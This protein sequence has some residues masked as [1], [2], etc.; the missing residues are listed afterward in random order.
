MSPLFKGQLSASTVT[1]IEI[2]VRCGCVGAQ[3][4]WPD[5][6]SAATIGL[7]FSSN[8]G[9]GASSTKAD[10]W[11]D[12]GVTI[13]GPAATGAGSVML[14]VDNIR[15]KRARIKVTTTAVTNLTVW[16]GMEPV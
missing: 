13:T 3:V 9:A 6:T 7:E 15:Q 5:A 12:S 8:P 1:Y 10:D 16:D 2:P 14:N 11:T 4:A